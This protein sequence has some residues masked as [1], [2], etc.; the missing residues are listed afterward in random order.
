M[1][2]KKF[3]SLTKLSILFFIVFSVLKTSVK[4]QNELEELEINFLK[5]KKM[6]KD[7]RESRMKLLLY[8][9][10][11]SK[12]EKIKFFFLKQSFLFF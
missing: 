2:T 3:W 9:K 8:F 6:N 11:L 4:S 12:S 7:D 5:D 10:F 1:K